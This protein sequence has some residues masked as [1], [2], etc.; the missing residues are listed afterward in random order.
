MRHTVVYRLEHETTGEGPFA[1]FHEA[2]ARLDTHAR[3]LRAVHLDVPAFR[4]GLHCA[5]EQLAHIQ[6][7][8]G[9]LRVELLACG[10]VLRRY[11]VSAGS[12]YLSNSGRQVAFVRASATASQLIDWPRFISPQLNLFQ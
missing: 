7:W 10:Y 9:P 4:K 11:E 5:V 3:K 2:R 12:V 6:E 8:F 1:A